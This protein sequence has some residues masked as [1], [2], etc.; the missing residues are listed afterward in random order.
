MAGALKDRRYPGVLLV[1][2]PPARP[3]VGFTSGFI[4]SRP[5]R[6]LAIVRRLALSLAIIAN[7]L[8]ATATW[9]AGSCSSQAHD[10][11][12]SNGHASPATGTTATVFTFTVIYSD[13]KACPPNWVRVTI[14]GVGVYP[15]TGSGTSYGTGVTFSRSM[16][17]PVGTHTYQFSANSG[18]VGAQK[19]TAIASVDPPSVTV[20]AIVTP[21][22]GPS[23]T[24][25][26]TPKP[27]PLPSPKPTA[28]PTVPPTPVPTIT[29]TAP[30]TPPGGATATPATPGS[31]APATAAQTPVPSVSAGGNGTASAGAAASQDQAAA[32]GP[33]SSED[34]A[35]AGF[36][37]TEPL[38]SFALLLGGWATATAGGLAL[39]LFLAPR[40]R[41]EDEPALAVAGQGAVEAMAMAPASAAPS[42][43]SGL[44]PPDEVNMPR[45]L[46][47]SVR[48]GRQGTRSPTRRSEDS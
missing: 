7:L 13:T 42:P 6:D 11:L 44:V 20:T 46:R 18:D 30:A 45:W 31:S 16:Q 19:T 15:M 39:F 29:P 43:A 8:A 14:A 34:G 48:A 12:L 10:P 28:R 2:V 27:T 37:K 26:P 40:P 1:H 36:T 32:P 38:G 3:R 33:S 21:P 41:R 24:P 17:L 4:R 35:A 25:V 5:R 23:A 22:P 47:P 9:G